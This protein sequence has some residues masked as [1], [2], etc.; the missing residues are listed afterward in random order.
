MSFSKIIEAFSRHLESAPKFS[1]D[2]LRAQGQGGGKGKAVGGRKLFDVSKM[3]GAKLNPQIMQSL[4]AVQ[5]KLDAATAHAT[6][7]QH[8]AHTKKL[9]GFRMSTLAAFK[10]LSE[11]DKRKL[12]AIAK[13]GI[14]GG[15]VLGQYKYLL[16][17]SCTW[18]MVSTAQMQKGLDQAKAEGLDLDGVWDAGK[19]AAK[20]PPT[21]GL[22]FQKKAA[23]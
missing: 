5:D 20:A 7:E 15:T 21:T 12:S 13:A 22:F 11:D 19:P 9:A 4:N 14:S 23:S 2:A 6:P 10:T 18:S 1:L 8:L 16:P 17:G 3:A